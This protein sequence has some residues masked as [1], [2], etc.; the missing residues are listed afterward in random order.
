MKFKIN[1]CNVAILI[2]FF[3][4]YICPTYYLEANGIRVSSVLF[5]FFMLLGI[6]YYFVNKKLHW[7]DYIYMLV[8]GG[9]ILYQKSISA[10]VLLTPLFVEKV[11]D[12]KYKEQIKELLMKSSLPYI[13]LYFTLFYSVYY[14]RL[15]GRYLHTG[16]FEVNSSGLAVL[17][18]GLIF[19][20]RKKWIGCIVLAMGILSLSRNYIL[21]LCVC[22]L[23]NTKSLKKFIQ[24]INISKYINFGS[25]M[26]VSSI[27][28]YILGKTCEIKYTNG[29]IVY[30]SDF[31]GRVFNFYD[32]SNYFRFTVNV[33]LI[34]GFLLNPQYLLFGIDTLSFSKMCYSMASMRKQWY[35]GNNPHNFLFAYTKLY[36]I[37]GILDCLYICKIMKKIVNNYNYFIMVGIS[38]YCIFLSVGVNSYWL[39]ISYITL[40]LYEN[41][42]F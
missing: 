12:E 42:G 24:K 9:C 36:G 17:L 19:L 22:I 34:E 5:A 8:I 14:G 28:L 38:I 20:K 35:H 33:Y 4:I 6:L 21:V 26:L 16:V 25:I 1:L 40:I 37:A 10:L 30:E 27:V 3:I 7:Y 39:I 31:W 18:L 15:D 32:I 11:F 2:T 41:G 29:L 23:L 13:A